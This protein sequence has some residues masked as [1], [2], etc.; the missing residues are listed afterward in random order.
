MGDSGGIIREPCSGDEKGPGGQWDAEVRS[1][2][3][4]LHNLFGGAMTTKRHLQLVQPG[5]PLRTPRTMLMIW[6]EEFLRGKIALTV[7]EMAFLQHNQQYVITTP[8]ISTREN[9][10]GDR[11]KQKVG[12]SP[13]KTVTRTR[14]NHQL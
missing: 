3:E 6:P 13:R 4:Q 7:I 9:D 2:L 1:I 12:T 14:D 10:K 8:S 5:I 11:R